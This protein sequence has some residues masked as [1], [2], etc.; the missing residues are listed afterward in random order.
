M[1][2]SSKGGGG[3]ARWDRGLE[4][5]AVGQEW[6]GG[7]RGLGRAR[8]GQRREREQLFLSDK[9]YLIDT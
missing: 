1:S 6:A 9:G 4:E 8:R 5:G 3:A 7:R 2:F